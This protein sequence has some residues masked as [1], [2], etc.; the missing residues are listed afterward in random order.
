MEICMA[1]IENDG[2]AYIYVNIGDENDHIKML[3]MA[4]Y[5]S[6]KFDG[7]TRNMDH[8]S[9]YKYSLGYILPNAEYN[10]RCIAAQELN[11][12]KMKSAMK[13]I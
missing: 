9:E 4:L 11:K 5:K 2:Y 8:V 13:N 10:K 6:I 12:M 1:A 3:N 7:E